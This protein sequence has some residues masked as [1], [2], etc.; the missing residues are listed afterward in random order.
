MLRKI[1][2]AANVAIIVLVALFGWMV[3][4]D[5]FVRPSPPSATS[6]PTGPKVGLNL[7]QTP[8]KDVNWTENKTTLV[9]G[10]QTTCHYCTESGPFFQ[11]LALAAAG[12]TKIVAVLPQSVDQSKEY[13][14]KLGVHVDEVRSAPLASI[15]V[16]GTPTVLLIDGKGVV[17]NVWVGKLPEAQ[18]TEV[19][20]AIAPGATT[21]VRAGAL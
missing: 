14:S 2:A 3:L 9:L 18:Q 19:L 7:S 4:R 8:L 16:S 20:N 17:K 1:E 12:R 13:L 5:S 11:K 15:N 21:P 6:Q 10:L